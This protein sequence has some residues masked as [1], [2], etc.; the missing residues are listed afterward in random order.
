MSSFLSLLRKPSLVNNSLQDSFR[1]RNALTFRKTLGVYN[2]KVKPRSFYKNP[3]A[4]DLKTMEN[5][6]QK[7]D[8]GQRKIKAIKNMS[9]RPFGNFS[10]KGT[11]KYDYKKIPL[12]NIPDYR[13]TEVI[14]S[15]FIIIHLNSLVKTFCACLH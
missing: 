5:L 10:N 3:H 7:G 13:K 8:E 11:F 4:I 2:Y 6:K 15:F 1:K 12:V 9:L 14:K